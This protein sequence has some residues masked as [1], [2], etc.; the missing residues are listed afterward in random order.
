MKEQHKKIISR[1]GAIAL[2]VIILN[3]G[4]W[5]YHHRHSP[6]SVTNADLPQISVLLPES[7][8]ITL[9]DNYIGRVDAIN[10]AQIVPYISGY[11][12]EISAIGGQFVKKGEVLATIKQSEYVAALAQA[13][14]DVSSAMADL[15]NA[16]IKYERM[17]KAGNKAV[18]PTDLDNA[19]AGYLTAAAALKKAEAGQE[20]AQTE[21]EYTN[22][23]APFDG[24]LGNINMSV[25]EYVSPQSRNLMEVVQYDPIRVVFSISD[26]EYLNH[27]Q[28]EAVQNL[29]VR[30]KMANGD[31]YENT[32]VIQYTENVVNNQT[33]SVAVY[34][35]FANPERKLM[36]NAYVEILLE[37]AYDDAVLYPK[38]YVDMRSDGNYIN[39]VQ[40]G[41]LKTQKIHIYGTYNNQYVLRNDF[42]ADTYLVNENIEPRMLNQKVAIH[43][44]QAEN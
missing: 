19:E 41:I 12:I 38:N 31:I 32:G 40:N 23:T 6:I 39:V 28:N 25:G 1:V 14:A 26:K 35:E 30:L 9:T 17:Q 4:Y 37:R 15:Y 3:I 21:L 34:A 7:Q 2:L 8:N 13:E 43:L 18:S 42:A 22:L 36:P 44:P 10:Q 27:F 33:G 24:V 16:K 5:T 20:T 11:I 29:V